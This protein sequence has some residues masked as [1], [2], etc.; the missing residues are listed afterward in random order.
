M[1]RRK[2]NSGKHRKENLLLKR[3][4]KR[5]DVPQPEEQPKP[6]KRRGIAGHQANDPSQANQKVIDSARKLQSSFIKV[7][8]QFLAEAKELASNLSLARPIPTENALFTASM[9]TEPHELL[10]CPKRPKWRYDM[11]KKEVEKNEEGLFAKWLTQTDTVLEQWR[12]NRETTRMQNA[13][14]AESANVSGQLRGMPASPTYFERN[15]EVWRQLWRV[16]ELSQILLVLLDCRCPLLHFPPSLSK[17]L[18]DYSSGQSRSTSKKVLLVLTKVDISGGARANAWEAYLRQRYPHVE[19][20]QVE[21]Y[22]MDS[23]EDGGEE[24]SRRQIRRPQAHLPETFRRRLIGTLEAIHKELC[25]PPQRIRDNPD[26]LAKWNPSVRAAIDWNLA[27]QCT[28]S[29]PH[30]RVEDGVHVEA[31]PRLHDDSAAE[32]DAPE[33]EYL[34]I[35]LIGQPNVGKSSLVNAL[36]GESK[37]RASK[38][39]GKTKH[40][41]TLFLTPE[42]RFVDCPGLVMPNYTPMEL[43]VLSGILPISHISSIPSCIHYAASVMPLERVLNLVHPTSLEPEKEDK[44]TW[45][46]GMQPRPSTSDRVPKWTAMDILTAYA[47]YKGYTTAKAG[48]PDV[49][50]AG[51]AILRLLTEG[52]I[53]WTFLPPP[54]D[55]VQDKVDMQEGDGIWIR[56]VDGRSHDDGS[57]SE[58]EVDNDSVGDSHDAGSGD[59]DEEDEEEEEEGT[60]TGQSGG[61]LSRF[62]VLALSGDGDSEEDDEEEADE[63]EYE[64]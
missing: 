61:L 4:I 31:G 42:I 55:I 17:Y 22:Y 26:K 43:Q 16:T 53:G 11:T 7:S 19:V 62:G 3:A 50:R 18:E 6:H 54:P 8:P 21:S 51:N 29:E 12:E 27:R 32:D 28:V 34:T 58:S 60:A 47:N 15:L 2:P 38:T 49:M 23:A 41:Q 14:G 9:L 36:F 33:P 5:G 20:V 56:S 64:N 10:T 37:V 35:G 48:R 46:E 52:R 59:S 24:E 57:D 30:K 45:R 25:Q 39:P 63:S 13:E 40:F 44:R 1:P